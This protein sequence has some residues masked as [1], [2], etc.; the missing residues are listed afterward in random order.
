MKSAINQL[1]V[2]YRYLFSYMALFLLP[3]LFLGLTGYYQLV[4]IVGGDVERNNQALLNEL[5]E[6]MDQKLILM[7]RIAGQLES[8]SEL[9]P[10]VLTHDDYSVYQGKK[11]LE[12]KVVDDSI[13][14]IALHIRGTD[15]MISPISIYKVNQFIQDFYVYKNWSPDQFK[16]DL[17]HATVPQ[18]RPAEDVAVSGVSGTP[19]VRMV[20]YLVPIPINSLHPYGSV[21]FML[22][23]S[24]LLKSL[25]LP[26]GNA[27]VF[28]RQGRVVAAQKQSDYLQDADFF[29]TVVHGN[30]SYQNISIQHVNYAVSYQ[31]SDKSGFTYVTLIPK[32]TLVAPITRAIWQWVSWMGIIFLAGCALVYVLMLFNYNPV[33]KLATLVESVRGQSLRKANELETIGS[34]IHDMAHSNRSLGLKLEANRSAIREHLLASLL[35]GEWE[36]AAAFNEQGQE[37]GVLLPYPYTAVLMLEYPASI[38]AM[39]ERLLDEV[40]GKFGSEMIGYRKESLEERRILFIVSTGAAEETWRAWLERL[41]EH[42]LA[43]FQAPITMGVGNRYGE[44]AQA[45]RSFLEASTAIDYKLIKGNQ[46]VIFFDELQAHDQVD[47]FN[48]RRVL[49]ELDLV[50]HLGGPEQI[51]EAVEQIA[52]RMKASGLTL[53]I[54]REL[55]YDMIRKFIAYAEKQRPGSTGASFPDVLTLTDYTT[56]D[57]IVGL[58]LSASATLR[59]VLEAKKPAAPNAMIEQITAYISRHCA[60]YDFSVQRI[61][62]HFSLSLSYLSRYFKEQTGQTV[63]EYMNEVRIDQAKRLLR[64][65]DRSVK[66]IVQQVG[67][68]DVSSFIRKFK[69]MVGVTPGE[70]R[71]QHR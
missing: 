68:Y 67:Y 9:S 52:Q 14:E 40:E 31:K 33:K 2:F 62:E 4:H 42:V 64:T 1:P 60:E 10:Y 39:K 35:K 45:G 69:Q 27:I 22:R 37:L 51:S 63:M 5:Q 25:S 55:I 58:L 11:V 6:Q 19:D 12:G 20:T 23:E 38:A 66:D 16:D 56:L 32:T 65:D 71:K 30:A 44:L 13:R 46:R 57:D 48:P 7:N 8:M 70:Y 3:L 29:K 24:E 49:E 36:S 26:E 43:V 61:A 21:L 28:D 17:E 47:L 41:H 15:F 53:F 59:E 34:V 50:L 54:A 18:L